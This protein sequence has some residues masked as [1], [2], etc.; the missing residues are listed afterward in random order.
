MLCIKELIR[1]VQN[2]LHYF[3]HVQLTLETFQVSD[4][5]LKRGF[6]TAVGIALLNIPNL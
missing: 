1:D 2:I 3:Y 4:P 5:L 6:E